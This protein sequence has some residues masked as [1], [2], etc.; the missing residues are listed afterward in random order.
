METQHRIIIGN[1]GRMTAIA[2]KSVD[3]V[4]TSPPYPMIQMW[5]DIFCTADPAIGKSLR[6]AD[7]NAAFEGMHRVLDVVW[8]EVRRVAKPGGLVCVNIGDATRTMGGKFRLFG[9]HSRIITAF[10]NLGFDQLPAII[11][12][13]TT[14]APN[15]FMGSGM[16]PPGAYVTLE[17]E[18]ILIFRLGGMREFLT[19]QQ[20]QNRRESAYFWEERNIWF[21][22]VWFDLVGTR[23]ATNNGTA[24]ERS[25]AFPFELAY[26]LVNMFSVKGDM[27][28]DPFLGS[29]T[30]MLAAMAMARNSAGYEIDG[31]FRQVILERIAGLPEL[32]HRAI[33]GRLQRHGQFVRDRLG[34]AKEIKY[35]TKHHQL[36]VITRQERDLRFDRV[37]QLKWCDKDT[38]TVSYRDLAACD[39][40]ADEPPAVKPVKNASK[41]PSGAEQLKLF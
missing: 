25:A 39:I 34:Q 35:N 6:T 11:W 27:I 3:L 32:A 7:G 8:Q 1:A 30:T 14:N 16:Y 41:P 4:V 21:S 15:K 36:P 37:D 18:Y 33:V 40:P 24:R 12:R 38:V 19:P 9:N 10:R 20:K 22:D 2:D 13:K 5:D 26:R 28:L 29:G 17:H 23:Q 31:N